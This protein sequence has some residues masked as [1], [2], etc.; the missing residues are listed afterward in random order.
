M[1]KTLLVTGASSG[2]GKKVC[3]LFAEQG[4]K[5]VIGVGRRPEALTQTGETLQ[6]FGTEFLG[7]TADL[8]EG[9]NAIESIAKKVS[10]FTSSVDTLVN[11]AG[12]LH[13][14]SFA[15]VSWDDWKNS[16]RVNLASPYFL[17]QAMLPFLQVA[18]SPV[19][20]NVSSTLAH[21]PIPNTSIYNIAK[22]GLNMMTQ[23]LAL[24]LAP[25]VRVNGV[26]PAVVNTPMYAKRFETKEEM[27]AALPSANAMHPMGRIGSTDDIAEAIYFLSSAKS[28]WITGTVLPVDGGM[29]VT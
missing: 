14:K 19:V 5:K 28:N 13:E 11:N 24:E 26:M 10:E 15:D 27:D 1:S 22:A 8:S 6:S 29:L 17:V 16:V 20:V 18:E 12:V 23:T 3:E 21:K 25:R 7:V 9:E 2:I 4:Y